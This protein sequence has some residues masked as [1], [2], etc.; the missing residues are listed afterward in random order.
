MSL[1]MYL[2]T[3]DTQTRSM[4]QICIDTIQ[5]MEKTIASIDQFLLSI[6][7]QGK[8]YQTAKEY[9]AQTFRPLAQG[10]I[11]LCEEL[12]RQNENYP[13]DFRSQVSGT[14]VIEQEIL[15]QINQLD[16]LISSLKAL[17]EISPMVAA[18]IRIYEGIKL[19]IEKKLE[20]LYN[21][22]TASSSNYN[23]A[24]QLAE[25]VAQGLTQVQGGKGFN[26][27]TGTFS[28]KGMDMSWVKKLDDIH[29]TRKAK[30]QYAEYLEK[31]PGDLDD[32][33]TILKYEEAHPTYVK[34]TDEFLSPLE[35]EDIVGIKYLMYTAEEPYRTLA[36]KYLDRFEIISTTKSGRFYPSDDAVR[37]NIA[38]DR[39]DSR[40]EYYTFFH[41]IGHAIDYYYGVDNRENSLDG[42][43]E[44]FGNYS[45]FSDNFEVDGKSLND[46]IY[47]DAENNF[48]TELKKELQS[49]E[50]NHLSIEE[51]KEMTD[52][53]TENLMNQ[54][55]FYEKLTKEEK[56]LQIIIRKLYKNELD[57]PA[58]NTA[59]DIYGGVTDFTVQG[60]YGHEEDYWFYNNG[61][62]EREPNRE[63]FAEYYG[64]IMTPEGTKRD[65]GIESMEEFLPNSK[66]HS[67]KILGSMGGR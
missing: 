49:Q 57:G 38:E 34:Q 43:K 24:L 36:M 53:V 62:R 13:S 1:N 29:Y 58:H 31:H 21:F 3:T 54:D 20:N 16:M 10:I 56:Q 50:Y 8:T 51:K 11:Y 18:S 67:E 52:N 12:I 32:I 9:M 2:G 47:Q 26:P 30:E 48:R 5:G 23:T 45:Y 39:E 28:T 66:Q 7:L 65:Q 22:N 4:N 35:V 19:E 60:Q 33:I 61:W 59:S 6:L 40:G 64:R 55:R 25:N 27:D 41:E 37:F 14:D 15:D 44:V 46:H 63:A 42:I 17:S